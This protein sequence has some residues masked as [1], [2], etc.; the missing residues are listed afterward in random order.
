MAEGIRA[1]NVPLGVALTEFFGFEDVGGKKSLRRY[2]RDDVLGILE[3]MTAAVQ[4]G[5]GVV[6]L[7]LAA[8]L[9]NK[10]YPPNQLAW[11]AGDSII[12]NNGVYQKFGNSGSGTW[13]RVGD[14]P[15]SFYVADNVGAGTADAIQATSANPIPAERALVVF[16]VTDANTSDDVTIAFNGNAPLTIKTSS[17]A[18]PSIGGFV[19]NMLLAGYIH[20]TEFRLISDQASAAVQTAAEN[21][22]TSAAASA[23]DALTSK[24]EAAA[25]TGSGSVTYDAGPTSVQSALESSYYLAKR[26]VPDRAVMAALDV[27][28]STHAFVMG[29]GSKNG[30]FWLKDYGDYTAD[31][32]ADVREGFVVR[33]TNDPTKVWVR[34]VTDGRY[35]IDWFVTNG[36]S[37]LVNTAELKDALQS[38]PN[39]GTAAFTRFKQYDVSEISATTRGSI[40]LQGNGALINNTTQASGPVGD[41]LP[42][43]RVFVGSRDN[44][45]TLDSL[46]IVGQRPS[47]D[48]TL[49]EGAYGGS[50]AAPGPGFPSCLDVPIGGK[51]TVTDCVFTGSYFCGAEF[52]YISNLLVERCGVSNHAYAGILFTNTKRFD[53]LRNT[54]FDIGNS[55]INDGYGITAA[56]SYNAPDYTEPTN[57]SG[58]VA[59]NSVTNCKRKSID[60][61]AA[62]RIW[63]EDNECIGAGNAFIYAV[64]EGIDKIVGSVMIARNRMFGNPGFLDGVTSGGAIDIGSYSGT[65]EAP[66]TVSSRTRFSV[67]DNEVANLNAAYIIQFTGNN[68]VGLQTDMLRIEQ[69]YVRSSVCTVA[70]ISFN[71]G[72]QKSGT[73]YIR[74]NAL[75]CDINSA[76]PNS[77]PFIN[78]K[79]ATAA[80]VSENACVGTG[81]NGSAVVIDT[82]NL[83]D[84]KRNWLNGTPQDA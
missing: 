17:G 5:G 15:Y 82:T 42:I 35:M 48:T 83:P 55:P 46:L 47:D 27:A 16:K 1:P 38:I 2:R 71:D 41:A 25:I 26:I 33:S 43:L 6:F 72:P 29:E 64:C 14:L 51:V 11:V 52:H 62:L 7:T 32:A 10:N 44:D 9:A 20:G 59:F 78:V 54:V 61:H 34:D 21:A 24:N 68:T 63:V 31:V 57:E 37:K 60:V 23:A 84:K 58:V 8:A 53:I 36:A 79:N 3:S 12:G 49:G 18:V 30:V 67:I 66:I 70:P 50:P 77:L 75:T 40:Y 74:G 22:A 56:T 65:P 4:T 19:P 76:E 45:L 69:N 80:F 13:N 81:S 28:K 39:G 73:V